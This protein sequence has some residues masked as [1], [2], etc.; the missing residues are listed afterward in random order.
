MDK[1]IKKMDK[2]YKKGKTTDKKLIKRTNNGL[3]HKLTDRMFKK[4]E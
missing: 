3:K 4:K 1:N 2:T